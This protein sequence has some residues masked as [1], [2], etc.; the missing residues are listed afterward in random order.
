MAMLSAAWVAFS[1]MPWFA[2]LPNGL[3]STQD[4]DGVI[5]NSFASHLEVFNAP[6]L[7]LWKASN[8]RWNLWYEGIDN[9][10][11]GASTPFQ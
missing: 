9:V 11:R 7:T 6:Q 4:Q 1:L 3:L 5:G 8:F 2:L 10:V